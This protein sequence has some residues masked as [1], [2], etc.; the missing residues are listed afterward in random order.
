MENDLEINGDASRTG[1]RWTEGG[2]DVTRSVCWSPPGCHGGCG[3]LL[4]HRD[5]KL[6]RVEGD[7][8]NTFNHGRLCPRG[9]SIT[10]FVDHPLRLRTPLIR[11]GQRGENC[12]REASFDEAIG[13]IAQRLTEIKQTCG[14][15]SVIFCKGTARD[16]GAWLPRLCYG[17]GSPNYFGFGPANGNACYRPRVAASTAIMGGLPIPDMGQFDSSGSGDKSFQSPRCIVIWGANPIYSNPDGLFGGWITDLM[18][19]GTE[20]IV[21]DPQRTWLASKAKHWLRIK[22]G[23]DGA[24]ALGMIHQLFAMDLIDE[25]FCSTWVDGLEAVQQAAA[26]YNP[27]TVAALTGVDPDNI[28][29]AVR[30]IARNKPANLV[31]GVSVDMNPGCL[32]TISS[33]ISLFVLS[34]NV[35]VPGGM[36]LQPDPF[37][38]KRRG[39]D[40]EAFTHVKGQRIGAEEYPLIEIGTPYAQP[41]I[42]LNQMESGQPYPIKAAWLQGTG[43]LPSS[44]ADPE[45]V[46]RLFSALDFCVVVDVLLTPAAV[47]FADIILPAALWPEKDS[48]YVHFSQLGAINKAIEPP[49]QCR[50][51]AEI[52]LALGRKIAPE[53]FP[54]EN[55]QQW[56]DQRLE[57]SGMTFEDLRRKGSLTAPIDYE[58]H[59]KGNLRK[60]G[61]SGFDTPSG[62]IEL[63]SSLFR[64]FNL[65]GKPHFNDYLSHYQDRCGRERYPFILTTGARRPYYFC[66]EHRHIASLRRMQPEPQVQIHPET[67]EAQ[68]IG[69]GDTVRIVSPFGSCTMKADVSDRFEKEVIHC[70][71]GWWFPERAGAAPEL[72]GVMES[73]VNA[74]FPSGLQ[75]PGGF[76]YPFRCFICTIEKQA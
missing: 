45:R 37:G 35:E 41:D 54:W 24:L 38:V 40:I 64:Q 61:K 76:G 44:F 71:Y 39:D 42:L 57:P 25:D 14:P 11:S 26:D 49:Q 19:E 52:I 33:L 22:P 65:N 28:T 74:L 21:V 13:I 48:I 58:K 36:V 51:D 27:D 20:L 56:L 72:F 8:E 59:E 9:L 15:E 5:G 60:D 6:V 10:E 70:D 46:L 75:G 1:Y 67:A 12:W 2:Y 43:V 69:Q 17:F 23:T 68:G 53:Y 16:I 50:S 34:G 32:G 7:Q 30:F 73:N 29:E 4:Y 66:A 47:A 63:D 18:K 31:W 55:V 62:K 3:V